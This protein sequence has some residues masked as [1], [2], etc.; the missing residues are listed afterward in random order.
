MK[1]AVKFIVSILVLYSL[2]GCQTT[3]NQMDEVKPEDDAILVPQDK[4][5]EDS[6]I[7]E[8]ERLSKA[9]DCEAS[10]KLYEHYAFF[11]SYHWLTL[12]YAEL[13]ANQG[14]ERAKK[15]VSDLKKAL[16]VQP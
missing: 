12:H 13:A 2:L 11:T 3:T 5:L 4:F 10:Y 9:G 14:C 6:K 15:D 1:I 16:G 7:V 8:L